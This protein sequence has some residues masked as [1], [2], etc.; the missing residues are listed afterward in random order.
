MTISDIAIKSIEDRAKLKEAI[1]K[2]K[3]E[4]Q[5]QRRQYYTYGLNINPDKI[6]QIIDKHLK[7]VNNG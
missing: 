3:E 2:I 5:E 1:E 4:I 7:E 6:L